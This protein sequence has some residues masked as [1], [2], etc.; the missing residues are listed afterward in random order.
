VILNHSFRWRYFTG[1]TEEVTRKAVCEGD[2]IFTLFKE[3]CIYDYISDYYKS[4]ERKLKI[5]QVF[6]NANN[7]S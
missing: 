3:Q 5:I 2:T 1:C 6:V 4:E 7:K